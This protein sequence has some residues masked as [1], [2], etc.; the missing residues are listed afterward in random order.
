M[1]SLMFCGRERRMIQTPTVRYI[2]HLPPNLLLFCFHFAIPKIHVIIKQLKNGGSFI[3]YFSIF[4]FNYHSLW[5][6]Y[7]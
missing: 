4:N 1:F 7:I 6:F 2:L 5:R 3:I